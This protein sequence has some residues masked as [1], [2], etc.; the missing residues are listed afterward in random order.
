MRKRRVVPSLPM[1]ASVMLTSVGIRWFASLTRV[2]RDEKTRGEVVG[3]G[4]YSGVRVRINGDKY[5]ET[6]PAEFWKLAHR[7]RPHA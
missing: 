3:F 1:G 6:Y 5:A 2:T 7:E 4:R